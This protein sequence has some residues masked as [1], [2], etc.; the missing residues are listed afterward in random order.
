[1]VDCRSD[2]VFRVVRRKKINLTK[3]DRQ[4]VGNIITSIMIY[5]GYL[6]LFGDYKKSKN[7]FDVKYKFR[8]TQ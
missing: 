6:K 8:V 1:M 5:R 4:N 7:K 3:I 2:Y